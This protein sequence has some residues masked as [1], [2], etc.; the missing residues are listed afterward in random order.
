MSAWAAEIDLLSNDYDVLLI[1]SAGNISF[2]DPPP[3]T[4][5]KEHLAAGV[6]TI[7]RTWTKRAAVWRILRKAF[8]H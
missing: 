2:S 1:Q 3:K 7:P 6:E 8:R 4:G 5:V